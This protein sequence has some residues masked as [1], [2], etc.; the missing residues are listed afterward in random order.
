MTTNRSDVVSDAIET[1]RCAESLAD[2]AFGT[3]FHEARTTSRRHY[4]SVSAVWRVCDGE[5]EVGSVVRTRQ[6]EHYHTRD[7]PYDGVVSLPVRPFME[8]RT[9]RQEIVRQ[10]RGL[11]RTYLVSEQHE[12]EAATPR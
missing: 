1:I 8:V 10:L 9:A 11:R 12:Q 2:T 7:A 3:L 4:T 6:G 5:L